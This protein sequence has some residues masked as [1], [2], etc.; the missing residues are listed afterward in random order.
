MVFGLM[1]SRSTRKIHTVVDVGEGDG[2]W[3]FE[4][5]DVE[6][7]VDAGDLF[8]RPFF[9]GYAQ[10]NFNIGFGLFDQNILIDA[11]QSHVVITFN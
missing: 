2:D 5:I 9:F 6:G 3:S 7:G 11:G 1:P 8:Q 4:G 10:I